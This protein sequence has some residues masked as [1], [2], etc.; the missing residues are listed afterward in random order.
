MMYSMFI[1]SEWHF[2]G[3]AQLTHVSAILDA[4]KAFDRVNYNILLKA[5]M[6]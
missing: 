5:Y 6:V 3:I 1:E 4:S 2:G